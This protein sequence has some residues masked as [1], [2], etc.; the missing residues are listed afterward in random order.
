MSKNN[1]FLI[2]GA[3]GIIVIAIIRQLVKD[4]VKPILVSRNKKNY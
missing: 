1:Y 2:T 4:G 3:T